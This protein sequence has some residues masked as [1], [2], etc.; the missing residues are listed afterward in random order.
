MRGARTPFQ[1]GE[2]MKSIIAPALLLRVMGSALQVFRPLLDGDQ[3]TV[4]LAYAITSH[5]LPASANS[6]CT[7]AWAPLPS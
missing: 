7:R 1:Q 6:T 3:I 2:Y 5:L 4:R